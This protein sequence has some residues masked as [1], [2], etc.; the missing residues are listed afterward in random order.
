MNPGFL[1]ILKAPAE[2]RRDLRRDYERMAGMI[3][4]PVPAFENVIES[5]RALE[6]RLNRHAGRR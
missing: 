4:G 1:E 2:E 3:I 6:E 5:T